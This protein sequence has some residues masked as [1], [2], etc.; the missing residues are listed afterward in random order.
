MPYIRMKVS[1]TG[2]PSNDRDASLLDVQRDFY[3][4]VDAFSTDDQRHKEALRQFLSEIH[5]DDP[6]VLGY[7][8][9]TAPYSDTDE[10]EPHGAKT[11]AET[12]GGSYEDEPVPNFW[13]LNVYLTDRAYG[14]P[15]EGGWW[16]ACGVPALDLP[17]VAV[18][19]GPY[20]NSEEDQF[21]LEVQRA[22]VK[23]LLDAHNKERRSD[24]NS[25]LSEGCYVVDKEG[26]TAKHWPETRPYYE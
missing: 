17:D 25:V 10:D 22:H 14:G 11:A 5:F 26:H 4:E 1:V 16:Y 19:Y 15:E 9:C 13:Y 23:S 6:S 2:T 24:V 8:T 21:K 18:C 12:L 7:K 3:L 20:T